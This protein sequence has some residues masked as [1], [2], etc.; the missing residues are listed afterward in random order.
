MNILEGRER[1]QA[2]LD[3][4]EKWAEHNRMQYNKDNCRVLHLECKHIQHICW[5]GSNPLSSTEV[6]RDLRVTVDSKMN[7]GCQC[8]EII[9]KANRTLSCISR[10]TTDRSK[11]VILPHYVVLVRP[12]LEYCI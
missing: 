9:R 4:L 12:Q 2:D 6:E 8:D 10:G 5:L 3:S 7:M 1:L 11:E